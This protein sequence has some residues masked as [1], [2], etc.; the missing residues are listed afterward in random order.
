MDF[1]HRQVIKSLQNQ[2]RTEAQWNDWTD[3]VFELE[4]INK[5]LVSN[6]HTFVHSLSKRNKVWFSPKLEWYWKCL[7]RFVSFTI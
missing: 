3:Y 4:D 5:N 1:I 6:D 2:H 7:L